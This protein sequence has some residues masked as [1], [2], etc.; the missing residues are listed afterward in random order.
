M[1]LEA[2]KKEAKE[3]SKATKNPDIVYMVLDLDNLKFIRAFT[4]DFKSRY[5]RSRH[6]DKQCWY[7]GIEADLRIGCG[8]GVQ[9]ASSLHKKQI[10]SYNCTIT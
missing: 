6:T 9:S 4:Q 5:E 8:R 2:R 7:Y 10:S 3:I 1:K